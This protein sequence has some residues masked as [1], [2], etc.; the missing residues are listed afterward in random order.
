MAATAHPAYPNTNDFA[1]ETIWLRPSQG[2]QRLLIVYAHPDDESFGN[3]G[4]IARY[5]AAGTDVHYV[6]ATRGECGTVA[7]ERLAGYTDIAELRTH[8][9]RQAATALNMTSV[10]FLGYRDSGMHGTE[11]NKHP[12]AFTQAPLARVTEQVTGLIRALKPQVVLTFNSYGGYGHP[13]H[14]MAHRATTAAFALAANPA[15]F[16]HQL[17]AGNEPWKSAKLYYSTFS[18][19]F[20][21]STLLMLRLTGRDPRRFGQ[22][23]DIDLTRIVGEITPITTVVNS[24]MFLEQ[25]EQ[26]WA[27][28]ASQ[29]SG[30][31]LFQ[32]LPKPLRRRF[33]ANEAF[34]RIIP[35]WHGGKQEDDLFAGV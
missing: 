27:A 18:D 16:P 5:T 14:I 34:T 22:N 35:K 24:A 1:S 26:A 10:H 6:C 2:T 23:G 17:R 28:H 29:Q 21:K 11:D 3:A 7:P 12:Q 13:D 15:Q 25:K 19:R 33:F 31:G 30:R 32:R 4:T 20:L 9:L 8:E